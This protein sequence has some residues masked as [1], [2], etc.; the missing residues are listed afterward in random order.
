MRCLRF[1]KCQTL[2]QGRQ[3]QS[4]TLPLPLI[5]D[6]L[7]VRQAFVNTCVK[8][9]N[10]AEMPPGKEGGI[11]FGKKPVPGSFYK[12]GFPS[13]FSG[14]GLTILLESPKSFVA[15]LKQNVKQTGL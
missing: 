7:P 14:P 6:Q 15:M 12:T 5:S 8:K 11:S 10:Q 13:P 2:I 3:Y 1:V 9:M 4:R